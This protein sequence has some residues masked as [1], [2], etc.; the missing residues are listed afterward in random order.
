MRINKSLLLGAE[1]SCKCIDHRN[2]KSFIFKIKIIKEVN[3]KK[4]L[5]YVS[6]I[7]F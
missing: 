3:Y 1:H 2:T 4:I 7:K 6:Y 5:F